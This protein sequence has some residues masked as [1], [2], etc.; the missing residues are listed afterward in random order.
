MAPARSVDVVDVNV[1]PAIET[2]TDAAVLEHLSTD[3]AAVI[4]DAEPMKENVLAV[5]T[6]II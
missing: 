2:T 1:H 3:K 6:V 5:L 4:V